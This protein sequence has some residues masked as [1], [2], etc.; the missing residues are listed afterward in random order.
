MK[1][2][3]LEIRVETIDA[4]SFDFDAWVRSYVASVL[5]LE[6]VSVSTERTP[7]PAFA[8]AG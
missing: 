5:A 8:E 3:Q 1:K 6:G 2:R 4:K 7:A